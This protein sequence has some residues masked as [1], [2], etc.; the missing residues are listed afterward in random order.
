MF[1][2]ELP[3]NFHGMLPSFRLLF[4]FFI[5]FSIDCFGLPRASLNQHPVSNPWHELSD[6]FDINAKPVMIF[7]KMWPARV[8]YLG[9]T[10]NAFFFQLMGLCE[11]LCVKPPWWRSWRWRGG[12]DPC[13]GVGFHPLKWAWISMATTELLFWQVCQRS[14]IDQDAGHLVLIVNHYQQTAMTF[15]AD[16]LDLN[17]CDI[18]D[19][20]LWFNLGGARGVFVSTRATCQPEVRA[21]VTFVTERQRGPSLTVWS[22]LVENTR[23]PP[24]E[25]ISQAY[26]P[27]LLQTCW[28][29]LQQ[30][31]DWI[32]AGT[33]LNTST[34]SC[35]A[36]SREGRRHSVR[37]PTGSTRIIG[38]R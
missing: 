33:D 11:Q 19:S 28:I 6:L 34:T 12:G 35:W 10:G 21:C 23:S 25:H 5:G 17:I 8:S 13:L 15:M 29:W 4:L 32:T 9:T 37:T 26:E 36:T 16:L 7:H 30:Q 20:S 1:F 18:C 24:A 22:E 27:R 3:V 14:W 31:A 2:R 38:L